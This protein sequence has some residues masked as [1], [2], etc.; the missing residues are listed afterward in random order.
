MTKSTRPLLLLSGLLILA[1]A[2]QGQ[3]TNQSLSPSSGSSA[4][5]AAQTFTAVYVD[6]AGTGEL[7]YAYFIVGAS[8]AGTSNTCYMYWSGPGSAFYMLND[9]VSGWLGPLYP[10]SGG[11]IQNSQCTVYGTGSSVNFSG[12]QIIMTVKM[13]FSAAYAGTKNLYMTASGTQGDYSPLQQMGTWTIGGSGSAP[14]LTISNSSAASFPA[15][16]SGSYTLTVSNVG[17]AATSGTVTV[18]DTLPGGL[19]FSAMSGSGWTCTPPSCSRS[20]SLTTSASYPAITVAVNVSSSA[21]GTVTDTANVSGGG[22]TNTSNDS[23]SAS[24]TITGGGGGGGGGNTLAAMTS[25]SP[26]SALGGSTVMF[27]WNTG[28]GVSA[29]WLYVGSTVGGY[30]IYTANEG[31]SL[32]QQVTGLPVNGST[33]YV[34]LWS[35]FS[36]GWQSVD[37]AYT[38]YG[39]S[40]TAA[41]TI[42]KSHTGSFTQG[43]TGTYTITASNSGT[44]ATT[45]TVTLTDTLPGG[46]T[47]NS[48]SGS[49]WSCTPPSCSRS[50]SLAAGNSYPAITLTVNVT[51]SPGSVT[52]TATVSGG[53]A[54]SSTANDGTTIIGGCGTLATMVSPTSGGTLS[55][56]TA[57]FTWNPSCTATQYYLYLG[58][59]QG[60][61]NLYGQSQGTNLSSGPVSIPSSGTLW[62]RLWSLLPAGWQFNDYSYTIGGGGGGGCGST[63]TMTSPP[64]N[65]STLTSSSFTFTWCNAGAA[66]YYLYAGTGGV[67]SNNIF[68]NS[69]GT[70]LSQLVTALPSSGTLYVRLWSSAGGSWLYNDY[71]YTMSTTS[72]VSI[73][74]TS[75]PAGLA[76]TVGSNTCTSTPCTYQLTVGSNYTLAAA[77]PQAG[78]TGTQYVWANWSDGGGQSHSITVSSAATYNANFVTQYYLT[79]AASPSAGGTISPAN[80]WINSGTPITVTAAASNTYAFSSFSVTGGAT[81]SGSGPSQSLTMTAPGSVTANFVVMQTV[82]APTFAPAPGSYTGTQTISL[83]TGTT[84]AS[85]RYTVDGTTPSETAGNLYGGPFPIGMSTTV[86]AIAY[87]TGWVDSSVVS[88]V[89]TIATPDF[90]ITV[91]DS[92]GRAVTPYGPMYV[93]RPSAGSTPY[94][95]TVQATPLNGFSGTISFSL[96]Q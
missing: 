80:G 41:W 78:G 23:A 1:S 15:G 95:F 61:N 65:G 14:D 46:L 37:Y 50:D 19:S 94:N 79:T 63:A 7:A 64:T 48:M 60:S 5:G 45:G 56:S 91:L 88:S 76:L 8:G 6:G 62:V 11:T 30:D 18:T 93:T 70:N 55:G 75:S 16:G 69:T 13:S 82:A 90:T 73:T 36:T 42:A 3:L 68:S 74:V 81:L 2:A 10:G 66:Q 26:G 33:V 47:V 54:N 87:E 58:N 34:R 40:G 35:D 59:T 25:P 89:F 67:G 32:S 84:G 38:A 27:N 53:G 52:N 24:T 44:A 4:A 29:Y 28:A 9:A 20:D 86:K 96:F 31:T 22:E 51:G 12:N 49:G 85:I 39:G 43:Q 57:T 72:T 71:T 83:S 17:N 77:T 92:M 21:S